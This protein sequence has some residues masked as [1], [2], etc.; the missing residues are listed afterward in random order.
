MPKKPFQLPKIV[1]SGAQVERLMTQPDVQAITGVRDRAMLEVLYSTGLRRMELVALTVS[2]VDTQARTVRVRCGKGRCDRLVPVGK[3]ACY[4]VERYVMEERAQ[5][6][7]QPDEWTLFLSD[8]GTAFALDQL[9]GI[10]PCAAARV[11]DTHARER[12]GRAVY[13]GVVG[14]CGSDEHA[15]LYTCGHWQVEGDSC[16]HA[17]GRAGCGGA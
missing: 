9:S 14:A 4:W 17:P 13:A 3:P 11:R 10:V 15:D 1:P 7:A 8:Y 5:L 12:R 16:G 6:M 2:D